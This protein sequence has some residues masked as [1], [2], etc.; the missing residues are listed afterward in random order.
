MT[1]KI[2]LDLIRHWVAA[3]ICIFLIILFVAAC[4]ALL[5]W[6]FSLWLFELISIS[7][8]FLFIALGSWAFE[9]IH[10]KG[11]PWTSRQ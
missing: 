6:L 1:R 9:K 7:A 10:Q 4:L 2:G 3:V 11:W 8:M 5:W